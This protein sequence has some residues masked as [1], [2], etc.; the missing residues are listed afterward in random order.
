MSKIKKNKTV[1]IRFRVDERV[2]AAIFS[3]AEK[4][5]MIGGGS[6][7]MRQAALKELKKHG[8]SLS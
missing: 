6:E 7:F 4:E 2:A 3:I 5:G 1:T 8:V